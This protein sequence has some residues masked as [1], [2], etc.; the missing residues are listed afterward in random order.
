MAAKDPA[1][2]NKDL[3]IT[4]TSNWYSTFISFLDPESFIGIDVADDS[5]SIPSTSS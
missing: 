2:A 4:S 1:L 5:L 3:A